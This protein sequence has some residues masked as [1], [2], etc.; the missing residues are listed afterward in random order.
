MR[1]VG[2]A[3]YAAANLALAAQG[4]GSL[5]DAS[6]AKRTLHPPPSPDVLCTSSSL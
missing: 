4:R 2:C 5:A 1:S 3:G 6:N